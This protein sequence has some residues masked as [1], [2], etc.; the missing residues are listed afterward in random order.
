MSSRVNVRGA[1][2]TLRSTSSTTRPWR[3]IRPK[4]SVCVGAADGLEYLP[5]G[6]KLA[7]AMARDCGPERRIMAMPAWPKGVAMAAMESALSILEEGTCFL[8]TFALEV[9]AQIGGSVGGQQQGQMVQARKK[10]PQVGLGCSG[11]H[12]AGGLFQFQQRV[13]NFAFGLCHNPIPDASNIRDL[14]EKSMAKR[15][16]RCYIRVSLNKSARTTSPAD[17]ANRLGTYLG[18]ECGATRTTAL[19]D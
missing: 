16:W 13:K 6:R 15:G 11:G 9:M 4:W 12:A 1:R 10:G 3:T 8:V 7:S 2:I 19:L 5:A 14:A 18:I 17:S